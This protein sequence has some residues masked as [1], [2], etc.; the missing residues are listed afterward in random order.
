MRCR[1]DK[2]VW[3]VRIAKTRSIATELVSKNKVLLNDASVKPS[4][5]VRIG[6]TVTIIKHTAKFTYKVIQ[7][8]DKRVGA[9]LVQDYV[10]NI[11]SQEEIDKFELYRASQQIYRAQGEGKPNKK[12]RRDLDGF[13]K[14][15]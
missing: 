11:T 9:K 8:L 1:L 10:I 4:K 7:L 15:W 14:D 13:L 2:I 5:E 12:Q 6:D 3:R